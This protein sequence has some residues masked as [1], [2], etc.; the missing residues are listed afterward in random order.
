MRLTKYGVAHTLYFTIPIVNDTNLAKTAD[1]TPAAGDV[2]I[3]K[4][5][6]ALANTTNLPSVIGS[7][8]LWSLTLTATEMTAAQIAVAIEDAAVEDQLVLIETY[9]NASGQH[10][11]DL[12]VDIADQVL[13]EIVEGVYSLRESAR[14]W[15][16]VLVGELSGA[17]T[18]G[19]TTLTFRDISDSKDRITVSVDGAGN[20]TAFTTLDET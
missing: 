3:S 6:G 7:S 4:D 12:D 10:A 9:G 15:N 11:A 13:D 5:G 20:R 19:A 17:T 2:Q 18:S 1:W 8:F 16:A 14:L